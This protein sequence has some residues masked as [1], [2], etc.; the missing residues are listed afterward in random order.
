MMGWAVFGVV[1]KQAGL[2]DL[3][4]KQSIDGFHAPP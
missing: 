2:I 3:I 4:P 1:G